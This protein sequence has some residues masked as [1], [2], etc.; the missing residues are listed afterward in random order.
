MIEFIDK[1]AEK[2]GTPLNRANLMAIQGMQSKTIVFGDG[3]I[4][5]SVSQPLPNGN[6]QLVTTKTV[7]ENDGSITI[8]VEGEKTIVKKITFEDNGSIKETLM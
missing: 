6:N 8:T 7:F 5:E 3:E 4:I 2:A 1:T